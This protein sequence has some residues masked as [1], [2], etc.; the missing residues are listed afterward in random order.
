MLSCCSQSFARRNS[1]T[2]GEQPTVFS[3]KSRRSFPARPL[4][5]GEYGAISRTALRGLIP[6]AHLHGAGV[7]FEAFGGSQHGDGGSESRESAGIELLD[8]NH[9]HIIG[10]G[11]PPTQTRD[12]AGRQYVVGSGRV[13]TRG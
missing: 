5:G 4:L 11:K 10:R 6:K 13:I 7:G 1:M 9:F 8:R 12:A 2:R 3:L